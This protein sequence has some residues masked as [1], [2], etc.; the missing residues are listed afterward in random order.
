MELGPATLKEDHIPIGGYWKFGTKERD[1]F[2][3]TWR[4]KWW[5]ALC[6]AQDRART[7]ETTFIGVWI[8]YC[9]C[10]TDFEKADGTVLAECLSAAGSDCVCDC[11]SI[12]A[13]LPDMRGV[14]R[15]TKRKRNT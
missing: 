2:D 6:N 1:R 15:A 8:K 4:Y 5:N 13:L 14:S 11:H 10:S 7:L 12:E 9:G 3:N